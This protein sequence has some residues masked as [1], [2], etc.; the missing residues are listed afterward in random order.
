MRSVV[1]VAALALAAGEGTAGPATARAADGD[2][3]LR[4]RVRAYLGPIEEPVGPERWRDLGAAAVPMLE[5]AL[6]EE[7]LPSRR[8]RAVAGLA[9]IGGARAQAAV[10]SAAR[11]EAQPVSVRA[12]AIRGVARLAPPDD[13][14]ALLRPVLQEA[15]A[16]RLRAVAADVLVRHGGDEGC[17]AVR[18][19][20]AARGE[21]SGLAA[22]I[23]ACDRRRRSP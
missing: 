9:A 11:D 13:L 2:E 3:E 10:L 5:A 18:A 23:A 12:A 1:V 8:A 14:P 22:A 21:R 20:D 4:A 19:A 15:G 7:P 6:L 16:P 17:A